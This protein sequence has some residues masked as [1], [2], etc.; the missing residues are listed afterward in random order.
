MAKIHLDKFNLDDYPYIIPSMYN[1]KHQFVNS[2][3]NIEEFNIDSYHIFYIRDGEFEF[4]TKKLN[5]ATYSTFFAKKGSLLCAYPTQAYNLK[6][7]TKAGEYI[8]FALLFYTK[9]GFSGKKLSEKSNLPTVIPFET[10][11][12]CE[13]VPVD[14]YI[15]PLTEIKEYSPMYITIKNI[16]DEIDALQNGYF[17][18]LQSLITLLFFQL[19]R[20]LAKDYINIYSNV[21]QLFLASFPERSH[22]PLPE[23]CTINIK[24]ISIYLKENQD[25]NKNKTL[26]IFPI[27]NFHINSHDLCADLSCKY[28]LIPKNDQTDEYWDVLQIKTKASSYY[29]ITIPTLTGTGTNLFSHIHSAYLK[30]DIKSSHNCTAYFTLINTKNYNLFF[31]EIFIPATDKWHTVHIP[32]LGNKLEMKYSPYITET[33]NFINKNYLRPL[34]S[35]EIASK[36]NISVSHLTRI[37]KKELG[38]PLNRYINLL[39]LEKVKE[40]LSDTDL[41]IEEIAKITAFYDATYLCKSFKKYTGITPATFRQSFK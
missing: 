22:M 35:Q 40:L 11:S 14:L 13:N 9:K 41:S 2:P 19:F 38:I 17:N 15:P 16:I 28:I 1:L 26:Q 5:A 29:K 32:L 12:K 30:L 6:L 4:S 27:E 36:I 31:K 34:H 33:L 8:H 20:S 23:N 3:H 21:N 37:F 39:K 25:S 24:D 10:L 7:N 18:V